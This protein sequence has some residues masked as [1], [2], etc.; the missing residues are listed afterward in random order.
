MTYPKKFNN[1]FTV[2]SNCNWITET[3][4]AHSSGGKKHDVDFIKVVHHSLVAGFC[5]D[6]DDNELEFHQIIL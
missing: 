5:G 3:E 2:S 4:Q 1:F 6:G